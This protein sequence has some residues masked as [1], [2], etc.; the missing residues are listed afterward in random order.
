VAIYNNFDLLNERLDKEAAPTPSEAA[1]VAPTPS[2]H[3][4]SPPIAPPIAPPSQI[5]ALKKEVETW[6]A[7][8]LPLD[9]HEFVKVGCEVTD[10]GRT[11]NEVFTDIDE[12]LDAHPFEEFGS[13]AA[14]K[15][16]MLHIDESRTKPW[17]NNL[18]A[19]WRE[20]TRA[21][22]MMQGHR[23]KVHR[24]IWETPR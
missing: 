17:L 18:K 1:V 7:Q 23:E 22:A 11:K 13:L 4:A 24:L 16:F 6:R 8:V 5:E 14:L 21:R 3:A 9:F 15:C 19:I 10:A 12:A 2:E 20:Y